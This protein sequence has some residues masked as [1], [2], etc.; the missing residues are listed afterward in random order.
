MYRRPPA[1]TP[2][3]PP[4]PVQGQVGHPRAGSRHGRV[5]GIGTTGQ[6]SRAGGGCRNDWLRVT[7]GWRV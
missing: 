3:A 7:G 1:R 2:D 4:E 6:G 5:A